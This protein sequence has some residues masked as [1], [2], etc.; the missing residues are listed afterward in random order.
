MPEHWHNIGHLSELTESEPI[1]LTI[2]GLEIGLFKVKD[3][4]YAMEN[5]CPHA[6]ALLTDGS[7][8]GASIQ[9][10]LHGA[11]FSVVTGK[12][13]KDPCKRD[14]KTYKVCL[15]GDEIQIEV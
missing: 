10:P 11:V 8:E 2:G 5:V 7:I 6:Y 1:S 15:V 12:C 13:L 14:L 3:Q 9:C 4:V